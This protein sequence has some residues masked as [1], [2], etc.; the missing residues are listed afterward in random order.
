MGVEKSG[1]W[2][3]IDREDLYRFRVR[4]G[5]GSILRLLIL[6]VCYLRTIPGRVYLDEQYIWSSDVVESA[7][8]RYIPRCLYRNLFV[9]YQTVKHIIAPSSNRQGLVQ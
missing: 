6:D 1:S 5:F 7:L 8:I 3:G 9:Y 2:R 4:F